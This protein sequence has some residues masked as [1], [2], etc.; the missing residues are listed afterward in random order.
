MKNEDEDSGIKDS[1]SDAKRPR[2]AEDNDD[3]D[4]V[5]SSPRRSGS[6]SNLRRSSRI[7]QRTEK[8]G[9]TATGS[10]VNLNN[11]DAS[12]SVDNSKGQRNGSDAPEVLDGSRSRV[13]TL[14]TETI[15]SQNIKGGSSA[16]NQVSAQP[17][18][19]LQTL[20]K[21]VQEKLITNISTVNFSCPSNFLSIRNFCWSCNPLRQ[22]S[23][24]TY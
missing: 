19:T 8:I 3:D 7:S 4:V 18:S 11:C 5:T 21:S 24:N 2:I 20:S 10:T 15:F 17:S 16:T 23:R 14:I 6:S 9:S 13:I 12:I 1:D 22:L